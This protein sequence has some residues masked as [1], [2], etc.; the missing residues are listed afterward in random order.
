MSDE[1]WTVITGA[2]RGIGRAIA[3]RLAS[4]GQRLV[5]TYAHDAAAAE[6][7]GRATGAEMIRVDLSHADQ[8]TG[9]IDRLSG[10]TI[11]ALVNNAGVFAYED[12]RGFDETAWKT[13]MA[14]NFDAVVHLT[15]ALQDLL[16]DGATIVNISS[17]DGSAAA[18]DS[19]AYSARGST[20][21]HST[22]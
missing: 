22:R 11:R 21:S 18:F 4:E 19:M 6:A 17:V 2:S 5:G 1:G 13:V 9:L 12:T 7:V 8:V 15:L 10:R 20:P 14:V 16:S 3:E